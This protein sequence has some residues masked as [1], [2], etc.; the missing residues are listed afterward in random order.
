[1]KLVA[2]TDVVKERDAILKLLQANLKKYPAAS[3]E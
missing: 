2:P 1:L 3:G